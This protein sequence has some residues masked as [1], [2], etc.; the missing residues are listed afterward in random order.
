MVLSYTHTKR[1]GA[2]FN[3]PLF[4]FFF[5]LRLC[6]QILE[7]I[8]CKYRLI[9]MYWN[10]RK[11]WTCKESKLSEDKLHGYLELNL[12]LEC[13]I[14]RGWSMNKMW[15]EQKQKLLALSQGS[16][17]MSWVADWSR[18][19]EMPTPW[20]ICCSDSPLPFSGAIQLQSW[21]LLA[22]PTLMLTT[23]IH[24]ELS[25]KCILLLLTLIFQWNVLFYYPPPKKKTSALL[26]KKTIYI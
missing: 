1:I 10:C 16:L 21:A 17:F 9:Y 22:P 24:S 2:K 5:T 6:L 7:R 12:Y 14:E 11:V 25:Y 4:F 3:N 13:D 26:K 19:L 20:T 15:V 18:L 23:V 8:E